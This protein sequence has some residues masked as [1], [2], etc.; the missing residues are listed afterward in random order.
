[1]DIQFEWTNVADENLEIERVTI[2]GSKLPIDSPII[3]DV[4]INGLLSFEYY[5]IYKNF[6]KLDPEYQKKYWCELFEW[7][8]NNLGQELL[9]Y[10]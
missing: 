7:I 10:E 8:E 5:G 2:R 4:K 9:I 1:M 3:L 6:D